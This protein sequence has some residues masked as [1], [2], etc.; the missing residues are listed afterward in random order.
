[1]T[2]FVGALLAAGVLLCL[3]PWMWP[4][5]DAAEVATRRGRLV[6]LIE[7]AGF[8]RLSRRTLLVIVTAAGLIAASVAWLLTGIAVLA[9]LAGVAG[10]VAPIVLLRG[11]RARLRRLRRQLWP[12]VCDLLIAAIRVGLSLPDAVASLAESAP[13]TLRPAFVVFAR[14]LRAS[15]RFETSLDRLKSTLADP[16]GDRIAETLRMARQVGGTELISVLRALSSSVRA[17]AALRGEVEARQSW[18]R[19]AAV[20][21]AIAPWVIMGLLVLRP[22]GAAAYGTPEGMLVICLGA[23]VS[24]VAF[25]IMVRIGRLPEPRR[26][27]G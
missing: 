8:D 18:I 25:H 24:V 21:G 11:R 13:K 27:F 5:S 12:D 3:S 14:D 26:W 10:A 1:M 17:D 23:A 6:R 19:G 9:L 15:G 22:E 20:L 2:V 16:I 7:E 4:R